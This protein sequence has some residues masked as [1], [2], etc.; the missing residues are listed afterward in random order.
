MCFRSRGS[1]N[2]EDTGIARNSGN[3]LFRFHINMA[4]SPKIFTIDN[5]KSLEP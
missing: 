4:T 5:I 2:E 3:T 1:G